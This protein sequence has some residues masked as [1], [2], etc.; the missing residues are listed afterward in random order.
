[1][2]ELPQPVKSH[3]WTTTTGNVLLATYTLLLFSQFLF[4]LIHVNRIYQITHQY[5]HFEPHNQPLTLKRL[6]NTKL[7]PQ[8]FLTTHN[9][10]F[11]F[12]RCTDYKHPLSTDTSLTENGMIDDTHA[13]ITLYRLTNIVS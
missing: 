1:M 6:Y 4:A 5:V 2:V 12:P 11:R 9:T 13:E 7:K 10:P 8:I 3:G